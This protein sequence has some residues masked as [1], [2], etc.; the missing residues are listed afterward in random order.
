M[1]DIYIIK[2]INPN[3]NLKSFFVM[4]KIYIMT[5]A[6]LICAVSNVRAEEGTTNVPVKM[7]YVNMDEPDKAYGEIEEGET[8]MSGFNKIT[9]GGRGDAVDFGYTGWGVNYIAYLQVNASSIKANIKTATLTFEASGS[10]DNKRT[11]GWGVGYNSSEWSSTMTYNSAIRGITTMGDVKWTTTKSS[12]TFEELSFD[13]AD[14]LKKANNGIAT[15]LVY[16]TAAAGGY[17]KNPK[18][19]IEWTTDQTYNVTFTETNGIAATVTMEDKDVTKGIALVDGTYSFTATAT[20]YQDYEGSFTVSGANLN[21]EF[22][23][24]PKLEWTYNVKNNVNSDVKTGTCL[25]GL[26]ATVPFSRYILTADGTVWQKDPI[27]KEYNYKF[28]PT[29]NNFEATLEYTDTEEIGVYFIEAEELEGMT[30]T[31][32]NNADIRCSNAAAGYAEEA[33]EVCKLKP[34]TYKVEIA[35]WGGKSGS[36]SNITAV[37]KAGE[38]T[39]LSATTTGSWTK[40]TSEPFT[41]TAETAITFSG[42]IANQPVDYF[43]IYDASTT[44]VKGVEAVN[45]DHKWYNL[46]GVQVAQPTQPGLYIHNGK[47][48]IVK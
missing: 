12:E 39:V 13:I 36:D 29:S 9:A 38:E 34:G 8:A 33:V 21:V 40:Y 16:E 35:V 43:L 46:Q 17:L 11:T 3:I 22:T 15:I 4:K 1:F 41:L 10:T 23:M 20:G 19:E 25:E 45:G 28:T 26:S 24:A 32:G 48:V 7:T 47:K 37:V 14:A 30:A 2:Q 6:S 42:A 44:A 31:S 27:N 18:V 5:L